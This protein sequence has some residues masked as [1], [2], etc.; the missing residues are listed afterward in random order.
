MRSPLPKM[1]L[2]P[3]RDEDAAE[4]KALDFQL[5]DKVRQRISDTVEDPVTAEALKPWYH[6]LCKRPCFHDEY[7]PTFNRPN[8]TLVDTGGKGID[9]ITAN[10]VVVG[11][12]EYPVD[13][14]IFATGFDAITGA[15]LSVNMRVRG[16]GDLRQS[17]H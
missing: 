16:G 3:A 10:G 9:R 2:L 8:V 13:C 17:H 4:L 5:M 7:L 15:L 6:Q 14:L 11:G 1:L 12:T